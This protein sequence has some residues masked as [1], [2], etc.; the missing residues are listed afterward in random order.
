MARFKVSP[1]LEEYNRKLYELGAQ[2]QSY[3]E[4][5]VKKGANP[6]ADAVRSN[7]NNTTVD[8]GYKKPGETR[9]GLR[10]IQKAGLQASLG[11]APIRNDNGF[12]NVKV[13]FDGYN[14]MHTKKY[15]GGQPNSMIA[16]SIEGGTSIMT[17]H[18]FVAPA[19]RSSRKQA[20]KTMEQEI[21]KA[22]KNIMG[23]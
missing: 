3:I 6:V 15:P 18:P 23:E 5:A 16:R 13:G 2:A 20:E 7:L 11:I 17:A 21:D 8:D 22:I 19:V 14:G 10:T 4:D 9:N 1:K 12:V